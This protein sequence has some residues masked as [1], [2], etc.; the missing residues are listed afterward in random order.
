MSRYSDRYSLHWLLT[1]LLLF[2]SVWAKKAQAPGGL[3]A[4]AGTAVGKGAGAAAVHPSSHPGPYT[5]VA[6]QLGDKTKKAAFY[7]LLKKSVDRT[8]EHRTPVCWLALCIVSLLAL[9]A[10]AANAS[11]LTADSQ[12]CV[13]APSVPRVCSA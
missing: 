6:S 1:F 10:T 9:A 5:V 12:L 3:E 2:V 8:A 13:R 7:T 11:P 4:G